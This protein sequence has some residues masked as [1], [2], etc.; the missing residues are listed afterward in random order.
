MIKFN[1]YPHINSLL[2]YYIDKAQSVEIHNIYR[3][4]I[5]NE[6]EAELFCNFIW[7][8]VENIHEDSESE[9]VVLGNIDNTDMLPDLAYEITKYMRSVGYFSIWDHVSSLQE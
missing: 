6:T 8:T 4:G 5:S 2:E 9:I 3:S 7:R 1:R